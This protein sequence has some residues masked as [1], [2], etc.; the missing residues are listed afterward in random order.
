MP[1]R[2]VN[3]RYQVKWSDF[4]GQVPANAR[5]AAQLAS[6]F[7][8]QG[9]GTTPVSGGVTLAD[10][11]VVTVVLRRNNSWARGGS[12]RTAA[13]LNHEQGHYDITALTA[14]DLFIDLMALKAQVFPNAAALQRALQT[15]RARYR[16]QA[17]QDLYDSHA[18][19]DH[20]H[21]TAAQARWDGYIRR[22]FTEA[23]T[24]TVRAP[25]GATYKIRLN[26]VLRAAGKSW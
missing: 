2:L 1:S 24:P 5:H 14:R 19:A 25:D 21:D 23:R 4:Q 16:P 10:T 20:G 7:T 15:A 6:D 17:I 22:A 3:L 9:F 8:F 13:L 26:D 18:E 11:L 12:A